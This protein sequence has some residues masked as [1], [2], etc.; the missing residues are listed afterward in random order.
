MKR[1]GHKVP[2]MHLKVQFRGWGDR[3]RLFR[4]GWVHL[5]VRQS[6]G[7]IVSVFTHPS[8]ELPKNGQAK[9]NGGNPQ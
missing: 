9:A 1:P 3:W 7:Q 6:D 2:V 4:A 5:F 8:G